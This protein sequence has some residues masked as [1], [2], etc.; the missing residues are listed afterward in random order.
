MSIKMTSRNQL[1]R[2]AHP[3]CIPQTTRQPTA[4][5][6]PTIEIGIIAD[7][8]GMLRP[9]ALPALEGVREILHAG[10]VGGEAILAPLR[11]IAPVHTVRGNTDLC[12][13]GRTLPLRLLLELGGEPILLHHGHLNHAPEPEHR[14]ARIIISGHTHI[15]KIEWHHGVLHINPGSAGPRRPGLPVTLARLRIHAH[16]EHE[17]NLIELT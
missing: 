8:H 12:A 3:H 11:R 4:M 1:A 7:T 2:E 9:S 13:W 15:P 17:V 16:G 10:D 6:H 14:R 5:P